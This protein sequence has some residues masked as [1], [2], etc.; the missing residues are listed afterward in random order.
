VH[1]PALAYL[2]LAAHIA[3]ARHFHCRSS[4]PLLQQLTHAWSL[5]LQGYH[6]QVMVSTAHTTHFHYSANVVTRVHDFVIYRRHTAHTFGSIEGLH[7]PR[8][9][10]HYRVLHFRLHTQGPCA[11]RRAELQAARAQHSLPGSPVAAL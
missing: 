10:T 8:T 7:R 9:H 3:A 5:Q 1:Q 2:Q 11:Y 4:P 6:S